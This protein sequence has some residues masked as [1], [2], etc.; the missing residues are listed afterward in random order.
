MFLIVS[1]SNRPETEANRPF[2]SKF[3]PPRPTPEPPP[4]ESD[5]KIHKQSLQ[6]FKNI[7]KDRKQRV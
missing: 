6:N 2:Y 1:N 3:P 7:V 4:G 5:A